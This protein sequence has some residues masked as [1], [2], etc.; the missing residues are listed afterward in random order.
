MSALGNPASFEAT[1][2]AC[3]YT[4]AGNLRFDDHHQYTNDDLSVMIQ[5]AAEKKAVLVTTEKDAVKLPASFILQHDVPL[6]VLGI[7][8]VIEKGKEELQNVILQ[9]IGG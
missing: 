3:G 6:W 2:T 7:E 1:V 9:H 5:M 4:L 8:I